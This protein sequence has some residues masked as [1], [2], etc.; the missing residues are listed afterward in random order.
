MASFNWNS[1]KNNWLKEERGISFE[2]VV[3]WIGQGYL[4]DV[5]KNPSSNFPDQLVLIVN[6]RDY[7]YL[8]PIVENKQEIFMKTIIPSRKATKKYKLKN[9]END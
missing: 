6:V 2:E 3:H 9:H 1:E 4:L 5:V 7:A 8:V